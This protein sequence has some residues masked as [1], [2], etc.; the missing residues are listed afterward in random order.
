MRRLIPAG[1]TRLIV[2]LLAAVT[3]IFAVVL[4]A[5][6]A[7]TDETADDTR[8]TPPARGSSGGGPSAAK[9]PPRTMPAD[10]A[11]SG[12]SGPFS[13]MDQRQRC[14]AADNA[15][16]CASTES[17]QLV[18]L[19]RSGAT[20]E[21]EVAVGYPVAAPLGVGNEIETASGIRCSNTYRGIECNRGGHGFV[22]G[23]SAVEVLRG[24]AKERFEAS[25]AAPEPE[26]DP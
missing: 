3:C 1:K 11:P 19:D 14:Q 9:K 24:P 17:G 13:T 5:G 21:G 6:C 16:V 26:P 12:F 7:D 23:D 22:I 10:P 15:V 2:S 4:L 25:I 18:R 8:R 20:Y